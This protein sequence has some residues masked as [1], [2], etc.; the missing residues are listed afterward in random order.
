[1][2]PNTIKFLD[3]SKELHRVLKLIK[4]WQHTQK[5]PKDVLIQWKTILE[6]EIAKKEAEEKLESTSQPITPP[7]PH[8]H[9]HHSHQHQQQ[10]NSSSNVPLRKKRSRSELDRGPPP[11]PSP[12]N[13][14]QPP[15]FLVSDQQLLPQNTNT[16]TPASVYKVQTTTATPSDSFGLDN[17]ESF[18]SYSSGINLLD[19]EH[20]SQSSSSFSSTALLPELR[21]SLLLMFSSCCKFVKNI[22]FHFISLSQSNGEILHWKILMSTAFWFLHNY[23]NSLAISDETVSLS[24]ACIYL[25]GKV[26]QFFM[27]TDKLR[28]VGQKFLYD[29]FGRDAHLPSD[30]M[31]FTYEIKLLHM[32]GFDA[33]A[34]QN[35]L[36]KIK[37]WVDEKRLEFH[38]LTRLTAL[39]YDNDLILFQY[40]YWQFSAEAFVMF[41]MLITEGRHTNAEF[42][43]EALKKILKS[44]LFQAEF[45]EN[46]ARLIELRGKGIFFF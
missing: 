1:L 27:K 14:S 28:T 22:F 3:S 37:Q 8:H 11:P 25:S 45:K 29:C 34:I 19:R 9:H 16:N 42:A 40:N 33:N 43:R 30:Q 38:F 46:K 41:M 44:P 32:V 35:P 20:P 26:E 7:P 2:I 4:T 6:H 31:I 13:Q 21:E 36:K 10:Q 12:T 24:L 15:S 17:D 23:I 39:L 18:P 5:L